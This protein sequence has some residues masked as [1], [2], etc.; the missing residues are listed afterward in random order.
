[1]TANTA[2]LTRAD[3]SFLPDVSFTELDTG[4]TEAAIIKIYETLAGTVL[5]PG[6]PIRLFLS[7]LAAVIS[8]RNI[9]LDQTGKLN[10]LRYAKGA[11]LDHIGAML[12]VTRLDASAAETTV[13]FSIAAPYP[14]PVMIPAGTRVTADSLV[15]FA[16]AELAYIPAGDISVDVR[17]IATKM[18]AAAN[19]LVAGQLNSLVDP[20]DVVVA[21]ASIAE[22]S[23]GADIEDDDSFRDRIFLAPE[24]FT[25]AGSGLSYIY[26]AMSA[27]ANIGDVAA[28]SPVPGKVN[29]FLLL[30]DG[31][32]PT[33]ES[34][35]VKAVTEV[36]S[37][38]KVR[39]MTDHL[40]VLP[41]LGVELDYQFTYYIE[42]HSAG[43]A[44][45]LDGNVKQAAASY[46][47][48]QTGKIGRD[49]N[50]DELVR[51]CKNAGVKRIVPEIVLSRD[52]D[53]IPIATAPFDFRVVEPGSVAVI[54]DAYVRVISGGVEEE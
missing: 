26:F 41:A 4:N 20:L 31:S 30:K 54:S 29:V 28:H 8:Q 17:V 49:L 23:G 53:G 9:I 33:D 1:M 11:Y 3:F 42:S 32:I 52:A 15:Y 36:L 2:S 35:E 18:G 38:K 19:G 50:P 5:Y 51:L 46:E 14:Y 34:P 24:Q 16:T 44:D 27:H 10:L 22:T 40:S 47:S 45:I 6:N 48:W 25:C 7:T 37:A 21:V 13:R 12:G 39:P 43:F